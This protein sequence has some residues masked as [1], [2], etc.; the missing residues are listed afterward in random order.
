[1]VA[2]RMLDS[3]N[4]LILRFSNSASNEATEVTCD[5]HTD[6]SELFIQYAIRSLFHIFHTN[7]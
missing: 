4:T 5:S 1:M 7:C 2:I 3:P 6:V